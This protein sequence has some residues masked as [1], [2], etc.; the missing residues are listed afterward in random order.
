MFALMNSAPAELL[1][2]L[3]MQHFSHLS[4]AS[5]SEAIDLQ[6]PHYLRVNISYRTQGTKP[7]TAIPD[8]ARYCGTNSTSNL[9]FDCPF[10]LVRP[11]EFY[12]SCKP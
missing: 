9:I 10:S 4:L 6:R 11:L 7:K 5:S 1:H 12:I 2:A 3:M 8:F